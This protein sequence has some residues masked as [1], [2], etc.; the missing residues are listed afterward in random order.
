MSVNNSTI[1]KI[2]GSSPRAT[3]SATNK[4]ANKMNAV[5][6]QA[7]E[8]DI[9]SKVDASEFRINS[10]FS[11]E[12][13]AVFTGLNHNISELLTYYKK[14]NS[15]PASKEL[16]DALKKFKVYAVSVMPTQLVYEI[17]TLSKLPFKKSGEFDYLDQQINPYESNT[18][19]QQNCELIEFLLRINN[20]DSVETYLYLK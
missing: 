19:T 5:K 6:P 13:I 10:K 16:L 8:I 3:N 2:E 17:K 7:P 20:Y 12:T 14:F 4:R 1:E 15:T 11:P 18:N 9:F